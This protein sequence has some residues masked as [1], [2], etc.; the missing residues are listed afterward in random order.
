MVNP[1]PIALDFCVSLANWFHQAHFPVLG[2]DPITSLLHYANPAAENL[3]A[4]PLQKAQ[5][6]LLHQTSGL[7][8]EQWQKA[9]AQSGVDK[10]PI[11]LRLHRDTKQER[12]LDLQVGGISPGNPELR[13]GTLQDVTSEVR[14]GHAL[15]YRKRLESLILSLATHFLNLHG[16]RLD[17][18]IQYA[19]RSLGAFA[20]ADRSYIFK[21]SPDGR[22]MTNSHEWCATG[23][24]SEIESLQALPTDQFPWFMS[25]LR[26]MKTVHVPQVASLKAEAAAEKKEWVREGIQSLVVVPLEYRGSVRG[27]LGFDS[28][29]QERAWP[30]DIIALLRVAGELLINALERKQIDQTLEAISG[31]YRSLFE[32]AVEG[33]F[34]TTPKGD[35]LDINPAMARILGFDSPRQLLESTSNRTTDFY[36]DPSRRIELLR[37]LNRDGKVIDFEGQATRKDGT[38]I[39][40]SLNARSVPDANGVMEMIEGSA[41]DITQR[42]QME[43]QLVHDALHDALTGLPNRNLLIDRLDRAMYRLKRRTSSGS[44]VLL[45]DLDGFKTLND[46]MGHEH[47]DKL[48]LCVAKRLEK[49]LTIGSTLARLGGDEFAILMEDVSGKQEPVDVASAIQRE[50]QTPFIIHGQEVYASC[51]IGV[52]HATTDYNAPD[53]LLRDADTAMHQAKNDGRARHAVFDSSMHARAVQRL[54]LENDLRKALERQEF[55]LVYQPIV[56]LKVGK[57]IGFEALIRWRHPTRG[58]VPPIEFIPITEET[59]L[60]IPM[61]RWVLIEAC[62]QLREWQDLL[63]AGQELTMSVNVSGRQFEGLVLAGEIERICQDAGIE[64]KHLKLEITES[65]IISNP[66]TATSVLKDLQSK[67]FKL[68]LDDFGTGYS[69]LSYLHRFPFHNLKIDRSFVMKL[70]KDAKNDEIVKAINAMA[71]NLGMDVTAEGVETQSQWDLLRHLET[72]F[73]QGY[74]FSKPLMPEDARKWIE[75]MVKG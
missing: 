17:S 39:W 51:S 18:G 55:F 66:E 74:F 64:P 54:H 62:R 3:I 75:E 61:G 25:Q 56:E 16:D 35:F 1:S 40:L 42:K 44:S 46:G 23:I 65:A 50:F 6:V 20:E 12:W 67:G 33:I 60:I 45:L 53:E 21:L 69:S 36:F 30:D 28:V 43:A 48:L 37:Q 9:Y 34:Q 19:L 41:M 49:V 52:A 72:P 71:R 7:T 2:L 63:P 31:R 26:A 38:H 73:G 29:L 11:R 5:G 24:H 59:G 68:S 47:G 13:V 14:V 70:E 57:L 10:K 22:F 32:N 58:V 4:L 8:L 27:F 15:E